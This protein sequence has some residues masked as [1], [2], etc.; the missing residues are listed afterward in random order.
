MD[1]EDIAKIVVPI[2]QNHNFK[3]FELELRLIFYSKFTVEGSMTI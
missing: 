2:G 3:S 1:L